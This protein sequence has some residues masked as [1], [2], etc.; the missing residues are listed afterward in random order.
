MENLEFSP[1]ERKIYDSLYK[2]A[3]RNFDRLSEKGL[4]S[5]NYTHILAM[6]MRY[7]VY[8]SS[9]YMIQERIY[10]A[11]LRLRRAVLHPNL[12]LSNP[13]GLKKAG[14][15]K[16]EAIDVDELIRKFSNEDEGDNNNFAEDVLSNLAQEDS[17]A[18]CPICLDVMDM[19]MVIPQCMHQWYAN[20]S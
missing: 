18:E 12:V 5:K 7:V 11:I 6:L 4:V 2:N 19:P 20:T 3:K 13:D 15:S 9:P 10:D 17:K 14:S 8:S 1:L 16:D